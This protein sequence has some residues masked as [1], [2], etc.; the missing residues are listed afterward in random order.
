MCVYANGC[1][2]E[3]ISEYVGCVCVSDKGGASCAAAAVV[4]VVVSA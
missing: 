1:V 3:F 2:C 4:A